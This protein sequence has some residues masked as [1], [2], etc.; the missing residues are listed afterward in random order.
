MTLRKAVRT[1]GSVFSSKRNLSIISVIVAVAASL[2]TLVYFYYSFSSIEINKIASQDVRSNSRIESYDFA[3]ILENKIDTISTS[4]DIIANA[5]AVQNNQQIDARTFFDSAKN[6]SESWVDF[7]AWLGPDGKLV[8]SSNLN[9]TVYEEY[10]GTDLS[11]RPYFTVPKSTLEPYY[12]S[13]IASVDNIPRIFVSVPILGSIGNQSRGGVNN[14]TSTLP[15]ATTAEANTPRQIFKG[16]VYSGIR[17]DTVGELL[18]DQLIPEFQSSVTLLDRDGTILYSPNDTYIGQNVFSNEIQSAIYPSL[19]P[20]EFKDKFNDIL[21]ASFEGKQGSEDIKIGGQLNTVS[22]QPVIV[23]TNQASSNN[24]TKYFMSVFI[25]SPHLLTDNVSALIDQQKNFSIIMI[26]VISALS[27]GIA[28]LVITW[29]K[30]LR[31]TVNTKTIELKDANEQL[32][33]HGKMQKEFINIAAHELRT[34]TQAVLGYSEILKIQSKKENR[35]DEA[36]DAIYRNATRLQHLANDILDVTRIESQTLKLNKQR[37]NLNEVLSYIVNDF[38]NEISKI[39]SPVSIYYKPAQE[40]INEPSIKADRERVTQVISNLISNAIKFT[41]RGTISVSAKLLPRNQM[42]GTKEKTPGIS[43]ELEK[44]DRSY[45]LE[46]EARVKQDNVDTRAEKKEQ[47]ETVLNNESEIG[48]N[49]VL[50]S[51][52]DTGSGIDPEIVSKLFSK[53]TTKSLKG[54]GLGL[55]ICKSIVEAHGGRIW[56][57]NNDGPDR[58]VNGDGNTSKG[59]TFF[60][61]LPIDKD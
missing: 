33:A 18:K 22:Y 60:F 21:K 14:D 37:F 56:A 28:F 7:F 45:P 55:F 26:A 10:K 8:W 41:Q 44:L 53:F 48:G 19:I 40:L 35:K 38:K 5:P 12:S 36:I 50:I 54:T 17:L 20:L 61:T 52:K 25:A 46:Q 57:E 39:N 47:E 51:I 2:A 23:E 16:I 59:A 27:L 43:Q 3:R 6:N 1:A 9:E 31:N 30:R 42:I 32:K 49:Q 34:P 4:L 13:V 29:N 15:N 11:F 58:I 24:N